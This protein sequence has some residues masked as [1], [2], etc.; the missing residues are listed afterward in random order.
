MLTFIF[1]KKERQRRKEKYK[2]FIHSF[3]FP[4]LLSVQ[5]G[6]AEK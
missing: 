6:A 4:S 1:K 3:S 5:T 2:L